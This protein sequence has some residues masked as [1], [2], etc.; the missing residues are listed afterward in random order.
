MNLFQAIMLGQS[1]ARL[2][3]VNPIPGPIVSKEMS[4]LRVIFSG[5]QYH[6]IPEIVS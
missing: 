4:T 5:K 6:P 1:L 2:D 3:S